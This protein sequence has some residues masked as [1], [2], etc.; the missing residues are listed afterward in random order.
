MTN[1]DAFKFV[2]PTG[3]KLSMVYK[4][5]KTKKIEFGNMADQPEKT[6]TVLLSPAKPRYQPNSF[7]M[8]QIHVWVCTLTMICHIDACFHSQRKLS[9]HKCKKESVEIQYTGL[10]VNKNV[11]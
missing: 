11:C 6:S 9:H 10:L 5:T 7:Q 1:L 4:L 2:C 8:F 3:E